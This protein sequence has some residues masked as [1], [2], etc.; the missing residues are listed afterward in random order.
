MA[1]FLKTRRAGF[2]AMGA[3]ALAGALLAT[4]PRILAHEAGLVAV[5]IVLG[6]A[7]IVAARALAMIED[8]RGLVLMFAIAIAARVAF[9]AMP[10]ALSGDVYRYLWDGRLLRHGVNP[11]AHP[12]FEATRP[13][14]P[15]AALAGEH[16]EDINHKAVPTVYPPA[17]QLGFAAAGAIDDDA[18][19]YK[20]LA[21][22]FDLGIGVCAAMALARRKRPRGR[23]VIWLAAP[24]PLFEFAGHGHVDVQGVFFLV[25]AIVTLESARERGAAA[26]LAAGLLSKF[27]P[28]VF[29][30]AFAA[31][32]TR[33]RLLIGV[34]AAIFA[35]YIP[36]ALAGPS[37]V[38]GLLRYASAWE[39]NGFAFDTLRGLFGGRTPAKLVV[40]AA[41]IAAIAACVRY[42]VDLWRTGA[43]LGLVFMLGTP[44]M[45]PWYAA[46][47][48]AFLPLAWS[49]AVA[50]LGLTL[51]LA[52]IA[53]V[54]HAAGLGFETGPFVWAIEYAPVPFL[55]ACEAW[56][57]WQTRGSRTGTAPPAPR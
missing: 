13:N 14:D 30:P 33:P 38:A 53:S 42:R 5:A 21:A 16:F 37:L 32:M 6:A 22:F 2:A 27:Y 35:A 47:A 8:R 10:P 56:H 17:A 49:P 19:T 36:F 57:A 50:W 40:G 15:L 31:R 44:T 20:A 25:A 48:L 52:H 29:L 24:I 51:P 45:M 34:A 28:L 55:I 1:A 46:W 43:V 9:V 26:L 18:G 54:R 39:F 23:A 3:Q 41:M 11:Y 12:P 7:W 4:W